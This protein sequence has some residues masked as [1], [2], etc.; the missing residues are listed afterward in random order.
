MMPQHDL[1]AAPKIDFA[2]PR[3]ENRRPKR[4]GT[5]EGGSAAVKLFRGRLRSAVSE[6]AEHTFL[7]LSLW[8]IL[9]A[10]LVLSSLN[11]SYPYMGDESFY[12]VSAMNML[13]RGEFL[14]PWYEGAYRFNKPILAYWVVLAG[15]LTFGVSMWSGRVPILLVSLA[16]IACTYRLAAD[17]TGDRR[18]GVLAAVLLSSSHLFFGFSRIAMTDPLLTLFSTAALCLYARMCASPARPLPWAAAAATACGLG[19]LSKGPAGLLPLGGLLLY[20]AV[21]RPARAGRLAW[22]VLHPVTWVIVALVVAPWYLYAAAAH[23]QAFSAGMQTETQV[24]RHAFAPVAA[25]KRLGL[26]L[27]DL[28]GTYAPFSLVALA[29]ALRRRPTPATLRS[30]PALFALL[31]VAVFAFGVQVHKARYLLPAFPALSVVFAELL[32]GRYWKRWLAAAAAVCVIQGAV[33][34][35]YPLISHEWLRA[36]VHH[37]S[38]E[39]AGTLG[40]DLDPRSIGWGRL[41]ANDRDL[42]AP[43]SARFVIVSADDL[44]RYATWK[45]LRTES[46]ISSVRW[47]DAAPVV[48]RRTY[49]LLERPGTG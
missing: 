19:C 6:P 11:N 12:T 18:K 7:F 30:L 1:A 43:E 47:V 22:S 39:R 44:P 23:P 29:V 26:Y 28:V 13:Q 4:P 38:R 32:A 14:S 41:Y 42:A 2:H 25:L 31:S 33:F 35:V 46:R 45:T 27:G 37:W 5:T 49:H 21:V 34:A 20:L 36:L 24:M 3:Q 10:L 16:T 17:V 9:F 8:G 48:V 40:F 15:Y